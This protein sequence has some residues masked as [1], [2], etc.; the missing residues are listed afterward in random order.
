MLNLR[1]QER[2]AV[3][4]S[5]DAPVLEVAD[6][7]DEEAVGCVVVVDAAGTP[8]GIVTDRDLAQRVVASGR[9]VEK[10]RARDV[11]TSDPVCIARGESLPSVVEKSRSHGIRRL[12]VLHEGRVVSVISLDDMLFDLAIALY[13]LADSARI[14]VRDAQR[15][16]AKRRRREAREDAMDELRT[17]LRVLAH[18][19]RER[20]REEVASLIGRPSGS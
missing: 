20:L 9:D 14:E 19:A 11:M 8:L 2:D 18:D 17:Q 4:V 7:M 12:P 1:L 6:R 13:R 3:T 5:P 15:L 16:A 10:T